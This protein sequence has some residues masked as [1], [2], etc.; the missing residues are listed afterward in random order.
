MTD[1]A[2][3]LEDAADLLL[4]HGRCTGRQQDEQGRM[5]TRGAIAAA[6]TGDAEQWLNADAQ[7][8]V[9]VLERHL[10]T[11]PISSGLME[12]YALNPEYP[13]FLDGVREDGRFP[14]SIWN[15]AQRTPEGD[16]ECIDTLRR[17]AKDI[18]NEGAG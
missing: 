15:D 2:Q 17:V 4:V 1:V 6:A 12:R 9:L 14:I 5:C 16:D 13:R 11:H 10:F 18:R 3:V 7:R 8:A